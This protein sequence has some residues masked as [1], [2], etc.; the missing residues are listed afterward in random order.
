MSLPWPTTFTWESS[1]RYT[2]PLSF[3]LHFIN[4]PQG[5]VIWKDAPE[6]INHTYF[7]VCIAKFATNVSPL[8][9][10]SSY[11]SSSFI[12]SF[13]IIIKYKKNC[14]VFQGSQLGTLHWSHSF[15]LVLSERYMLSNQQREGTWHMLNLDYICL[16]VHSSCKDCILKDLS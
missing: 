10:S 12:F 15:Q 4:K 16:Y 6:S 13:F 1:L 3:S 2:F 7:H 9:S 14:I 5:E 8:S 11:S